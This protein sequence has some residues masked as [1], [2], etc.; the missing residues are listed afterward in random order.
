MR[1]AVIVTF[2][3]TS[4]FSALTFGCSSSSDDGVSNNSN[5]SVESFVVGGTFDALPFKPVDGMGGFT[6]LDKDGL[7]YP[8]GS[9]AQSVFRAII[10]DR[11][12]LCGAGSVRPNETMLTIA[13]YGDGLPFQ[14]GT[15]DTAM[16]EYNSGRAD[17]SL[18]TT[19]ETCSNTSF[20]HY[21]AV[22]GTVVITSVTPTSVAG[23]FDVTLEGDLGTLQGS[24]N[25]PLCPSSVWPETVS[26]VP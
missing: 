9:N 22:S 23:T 16:S 14:P 4:V 1:I 21:F 3:A 24:F 25:V 17:V 7:P 6:T 19:D 26:C 11:P 15:Y 2:V 8:V 13:A 10:S 18:V 20:P 12:D 5:E